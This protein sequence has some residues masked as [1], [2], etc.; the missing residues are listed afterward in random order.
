MTEYG[1]HEFL[2]ESEY[3][4]DKVKQNYS[5]RPHNSF[6]EN[7]KGTKMTVKNGI[8]RSLNYRNLNTSRKNHTN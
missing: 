6:H 2:T 4:A 5:C 7:K 1:C 3:N 8:S